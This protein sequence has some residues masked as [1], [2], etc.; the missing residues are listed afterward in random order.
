MTTE[1]LGKVSAQYLKQHLAD[2]EL[3]GTAR[4]LL[5]CMTAEQT[6]A[7]ANAILNDASLFALVDIKLPRHFVG[8]FDLPEE[9]LTNERATYFRNATCQKSAWLL[10]NVGDDEQQGLTEL[11]P[12]GASQLLVYPDLWVAF[13]AEALP[14]T[15]DHKKWWVQA[16]KGLVDAGLMISKNITTP[17]TNEIKT[18]ASIL[19]MN[20]NILSTFI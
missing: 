16:L 10:V 4:Y 1:L 3:S 8:D 2:E 9:I 15:N 13:A 17:T 14:L 5:D 7:V 6:A 11:V 18:I 12:I 20:N 19:I